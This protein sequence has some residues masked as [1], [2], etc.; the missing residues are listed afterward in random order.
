MQR[1]VYQQLLKWKHSARR[2]PLILRGARQVG[3]TYLLKAFAKAEYDNSIYVNFDKEQGLASYFQQSLHPSRI[4]ENLSIHF[5]QAILPG[6]TLLIFD[7]IQD[8]PEAL[9]AL[10]YFMEDA[11]AYHVAAAGSLLGVI[12]AEAGFPVGKVHFLDLYPMSFFEYLSAVGKHNWRQALVSATIQSGI[13]EP[14][15]Q[16]LLRALCFYLVIGGMPEAIATYLDSQNLQEVREVQNAI[17]LA[18]Q[19]DFAKHAPK[20][21]VMKI[22]E[23]WAAI[24]NQFAKENKKFIFSAIHKSARGRDYEFALEWLARAGVVH[25]ISRINMPKIPL[26]AYADSRAF[27]VYLLD[28]GLLGAMSHLPMRLAVEQS[29]LFQEFKGALIENFVGQELMASAHYPLFYWSSG[30]TA[31]LDYV[32]QH[33][34][35]AYPLEVKAGQSRHKKSLMVYDQRYQPM[36]L[37]RATSM[38]LK[39]DGKLINYPLYLISQFPL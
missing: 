37:S 34:L 24:P 38:N 30:A 15:H 33:E 9:N 21:Q 31:E 4:I 2:K 26:S 8:C 14:L 28:V 36:V 29:Q 32:I 25:R 23:I 27:K 19:L 22:M 16:E 3:K 12:L 18:Y 5:G 10:K 7:E 35:I 1:D 6:Q 11:D 20:A 17:L 39:Q 13:P